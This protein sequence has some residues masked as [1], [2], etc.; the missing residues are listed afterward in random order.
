MKRSGIISIVHF[1][2]LAAITMPAL[3]VPIAVTWDVT[4]QQKYDITGATRLTRTLDRSYTGGSQQVTMIIDP[5][6]GSNIDNPATGLK[7]SEFSGVQQT[8]NSINPLVSAFRP[9]VIPPTTGAGSLQVYDQLDLHSTTPSGS[10]TLEI[11]TGNFAK[12]TEVQPS[13]VKKT[14]NWRYSQSLRSS[15]DI[16][17]NHSLA[18]LQ[19]FSTTEVLNIINDMYASG[20]VFR[21]NESGFRSETTGFGSF[22][23]TRNYLGVEYSG[24]ARIAGISVA[25]SAPEPSVWLLITAGLIITGLAGAYRSRQG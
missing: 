4:L 21:F 22:S 19:F 10:S 3:A 15:F 23:S 17:G 7:V 16:N 14:I 20:S 25:A 18:D 2:A 13:G 6:A 24:F 9:A 1:L 8:S 12:Q 11:K 5:V